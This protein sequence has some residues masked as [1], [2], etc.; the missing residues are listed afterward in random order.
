MFQFENIYALFLAAVILPVG[1]IFWWFMLWR[2]SRMKIL[3][4]QKI[5]GFLLSDV[6]SNKPIVKFIL[7][8][9][10]S[11]LLVICLS[12]PGNTWKDETI[13]V[14]TKGSDI[15]IALDLSSSMNA[16]D[17]MP[18][19]LEYA[20]RAIQKLV[21][22][23]QG[24]RLGLVVFAGDAYVQLPITTD[25]SA[26]KLFLKR[27]STSMIGAQ[28]TNIAAAID[29]C[30]ESFSKQSDA[31]KAIILITDGEDHSK[32]AIE[33]AE[34]A[35]EENVQVHTIGLGSSDGV[36][37]PVYRGK[38]RIGFKQNKRGETVVTHLNESLLIDIA[39]AGGGTYV[40]AT[41]ANSG[42]GKITSDI[43]MLDKSED[44]VQQ[45]VNFYSHYQFFLAAAILLLILESSIS[46]KK[47][48]WLR[49]IKI[50]D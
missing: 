16:E 24:D 42:L 23:L 4:S 34:K 20:K 36:P 19:R 32:S 49:D 6:S 3:G 43:R 38:R 11:L 10:A 14:T 25:R 5:S 7:F 28:G 33:A 27:V 31:G 39:D 17:L 8:A 46:F 30:L 40:R 44:S 26:A 18:N 29:K 22:E 1:L 37:I 47:S 48:I 12:N 15:M 21:G 2:K 41:N 50:F 9:I 45:G 13:E 35:K